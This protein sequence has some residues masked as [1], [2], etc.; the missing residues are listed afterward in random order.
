MS[1]ASMSA[2]SAGDGRYAECGPGAW[3]GGYRWLWIPFAVI[4]GGIVAF[5]ILAALGIGPYF[6][7]PFPFFWPVVPLLFFVLVLAWF[8]SARGRWY[9]RGW[10]YADP[11]EI[12]RVR[13]ARGEIS[14]DEYRQLLLELE[15]S[16]GA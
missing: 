16:K 10:G 15:R 1:A 14:P 5:G 2:P 8:A 9:G 6:P 3:G 11:H 13:L 4:L 12:L 7:G